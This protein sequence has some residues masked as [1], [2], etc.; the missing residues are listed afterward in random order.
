MVIGSF[1]SFIMNDN[2]CACVLSL[3]RTLSMLLAAMN[4]GDVM[5]KI[6]SDEDGDPAIAVGIPL[7]ECRLAVDVTLMAIR[8]L[9]K[10]QGTPSVQAQ[11]G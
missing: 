7:F 3:Q 2:L 5:S 9:A 1:F 4:W 11:A 10:R 6:S 8:S